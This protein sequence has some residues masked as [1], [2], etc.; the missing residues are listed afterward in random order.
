MQVR[1]KLPSGP[2]I[3]YLKFCRVIAEAVCPI[4]KDLEGIK[5]VLAKIYPPDVPTPNFG[6]GVPYSLEKADRQALAK[7]LPKLPPLR[8]PMSE[9]KVALFM[10][11]Y[12]NLP[13]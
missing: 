3:H 4:D 11:A 2:L 7:V 9:E 6:P 5:C 13:K 12:V 8:H 10:E 1:V